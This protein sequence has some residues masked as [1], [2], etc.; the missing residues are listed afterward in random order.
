MSCPYYVFKKKRQH[1]CLMYCKSQNVNFILLFTLTGKKHYRK[2]YN[3]RRA[4]C[5]LYSP[6]N[7]ELPV[8]GSKP[9]TTAYCV[10]SC[11]TSY[12]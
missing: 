6:V 9:E 12:C 8:M 3:K 10:L 1:A 5:F 11:L 7:C 2:K 4:A